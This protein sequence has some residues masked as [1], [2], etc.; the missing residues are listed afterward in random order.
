MGQAFFL[1][2]G[3]RVGLLIESIKILKVA[4]KLLM[5]SPNLLIGYRALV[6]AHFHSRKN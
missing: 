5:A 2:W 1:F 4:G 3:N 6:E